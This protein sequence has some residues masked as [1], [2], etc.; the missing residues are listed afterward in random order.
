MSTPDALNR[1]PLRNPHLAEPQNGDVV[2]C[3]VGPTAL[4]YA[5]RVMPRPLQIVY[6]TFREAT[7]CATNFATLDQVD[8]W[9]AH[10]EGVFVLLETHRRSE[11]PHRP[12]TAGEHADSRR[13]AGGPPPN[14]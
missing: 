14:S 7:A 9:V 11:T 13:S 6:P 4:A 12:T 5:L 3:R 1:T 10:E 8:V 2:I